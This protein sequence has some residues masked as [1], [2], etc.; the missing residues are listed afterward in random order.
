LSVTLLEER[1]TRLPS[2]PLM[3]IRRKTQ[4]HEKVNR[5]I[6]SRRLE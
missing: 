4:L 3:S 6:Q 2:S 5:M 1:A